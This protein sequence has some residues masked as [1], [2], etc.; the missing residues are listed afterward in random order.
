M[1]L[2]PAWIVAIVLAI[3]LAGCGFH[4]RGAESTRLPYRTMTIA[5]PETAEVAIGLK[6]QILATGSTELLD[7]GKEA[8]AI[9]QQVNDS[10]Q[11]S[12]L[13]VNSSGLVREYRL[14]L[15]YSFRIINNK[16]QELVPTNEISLYRDVSY[17]DSAVL[18]KGIEETVLWRDMTSDLIRQIMRRMATVKPRDPNAEA[19]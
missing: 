1:R 17:S 9:F 3:T 8:E 10:R 14:L 15:T 19:Q 13:S 2:L 4:L 7:D 6:R 18:A 16:G 12:I 5:L 11:K